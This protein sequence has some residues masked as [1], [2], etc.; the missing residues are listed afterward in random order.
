MKRCG[1]NLELIAFVTVIL[2]NLVV[3]A[4]LDPSVIFGMNQ[5]PSGCKSTILLAKGRSATSTM[6]YSLE[7]STSMS[8]CGWQWKGNW[9]GEPVKE[10]FRDAYLPSKGF[11]SNCIY[12]RGGG[13][14]LIHVKPEHLIRNDNA[15]LQTPNAF[16]KAAKVRTIIYWH[17]HSRSY[18]HQP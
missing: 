18:S 6:T 1:E 7:E 15:E 12:W 16:F 11:L 2:L 10:P 8:Y 14:A 9:Y 17:T 4:W 3:Q 5:A 13:G